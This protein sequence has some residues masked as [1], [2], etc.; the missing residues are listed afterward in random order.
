MVPKFGLTK[1]YNKD[2]DLWSVTP[3]SLEAQNTFIVIC[4]SESDAEEII[5]HIRTRNISPVLD[6]DHF[7]K[8]DELDG[9]PIFRRVFHR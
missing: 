6:S 4:N 2:N 7:E 3:N 9:T 5:E 8:V 1:S